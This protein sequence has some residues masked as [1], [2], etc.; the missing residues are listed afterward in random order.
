VAVS[1]ALITSPDLVIGDEPTANLDG[2][3]AG[4]IMDLIFALVK[5]QQTTFVLVTHDMDLAGR[6]DRRYE[7]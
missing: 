7:L 2:E 6:F 3:N 4:A 5:E 1:R